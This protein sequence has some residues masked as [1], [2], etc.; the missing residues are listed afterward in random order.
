MWCTK[1]L[2]QCKMNYF[3]IYSKH[4]KQMHPHIRTWH[5]KYI[6]QSIPKNQTNRQY[7][8]KATIFS[9]LDIASCSSYCTQFIRTSNAIKTFNQNKLHL[10]CAVA[11][12]WL[13]YLF[14]TVTIISNKN[15][16]EIKNVN[17]KIFQI[18]FN[19]LGN[20]E[21]MTTWIEVELA[22]KSKQIRHQKWF[23]FSVHQK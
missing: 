21:S 16:F 3:H 11:Q 8:G 23:N 13:V 10:W 12:F 14:T 22:K 7:G 5:I 20:S 2:N 9:T 1:G 19:Y 4:F 15:S 6:Q 18:F 17:I